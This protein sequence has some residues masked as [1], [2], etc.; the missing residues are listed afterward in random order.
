[1]GVMQLVAEE[2]IEGEAAGLVRSLVVEDRCGVVGLVTQVARHPLGQAV[3][4]TE[5]VG[6]VA[7]YRLRILTVTIDRSVWLILLRNGAC[8]ICLICLTRE[9]KVLCVVCEQYCQI[10]L[11]LCGENKHDSNSLIIYSMNWNSANSANIFQTSL[12]IP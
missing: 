2:F 4:H 10:M 9:Y 5:E 11:D 3:V 8:F 6:V 1:M 7:E 12:F